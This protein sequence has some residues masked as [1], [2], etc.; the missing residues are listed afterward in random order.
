MR[1]Q[2]ISVFLCTIIMTMFLSA[3]GKKEETPSQPTVVEIPVEE[4]VTSQAVDKDVEEAVEDDVVATE[5]DKGNTTD[6]KQVVS[7]TP[8]KNSA[9]TTRSSEAVVHQ[10]QYGA[11]V[12]GHWFTCGC[13]A[14]KAAHESDTLGICSICGVDV[15]ELEAQRDALLAQSMSNNVTTRSASDDS[16]EDS[17]DDKSE[18][19]TTNTPTVTPNPEYPLTDADPLAK[20]IEVLN[21]ALWRER[22]NGNPMFSLPVKDFYFAS[23]DVTASQMKQEIDSLIGQVPCVK[24]ITYVTSQKDG[25]DLDSHATVYVEEDALFGSRQAFD[26]AYAKA[27]SEHVPIKVEVPEDDMEEGNTEGEKP[28][29]GL[30]EIDLLNMT[31]KVERAISSMSAEEY[32]RFRLSIYEFMLSYAL[33]CNAPQTQ[34]TVYTNRYG[35]PYVMDTCEVSFEDFIQ[36]FFEY[37]GLYYSLQQY[38]S[39]NTESDK[40]F[41]VKMVYPIID[42]HATE[43]CFWYEAI[44]Q[45]DYDT[46]RLKFTMFPVYETVENE[47]G[48]LVTD[49]SRYKSIATMA[50]EVNDKLNQVIEDVIEPDMSTF[51]KEYALFHYCDTYYQYDDAKGGMLG[52]CYAIYDN[53]YAIG[54][55][56][57]PDTGKKDEK[58]TET[59]T[60]GKRGIYTTAMT[61]WGICVGHADFFHALCTKVGIQCGFQSSDTHTW[62]TVTINGSSYIVDVGKR[63]PYPHFNISGSWKDTYTVIDPEIYDCVKNEEWYRNSVYSTSIYQAG[64]VASTTQ[65]DGEWVYYINFDDN[66]SLYKINV[67]GTGNTKVCDSGTTIEAGYAWLTQPPVETENEEVQ[68][69]QAPEVWKDQWETA[70][71][72]PQYSGEGYTQY[73]AFDYRWA[74]GHN[75][76]LLK[77]NGEIVYKVNNLSKTETIPMTPKKEDVIKLTLYNNDA[78]YNL[79]IISGYATVDTAKSPED[80]LD[81]ILAVVDGIEYPIE[82]LTE[83]ENGQRVDFSFRLPTDNGMNHHD[84]EIMVVTEKG[85][86]SRKSVATQTVHP[87]GI[88]ES[89]LWNDMYYTINGITA[90]E[91]RLFIFMERYTEDGQLDKATTL[92]INGYRG[93]DKMNTSFVTYEEMPG[94]FSVSTEGG[95]GF[96][97]QLVED[98]RLAIGLYDNDQVYIQSAEEFCYLAEAINK[99]KFQKATVEVCAELDFS[100]LPDGMDCPPIGLNKAFMGKWHGNNYKMSGWSGDKHVFGELRNATLQDVYISD[101]NVLGDS[102]AGIIGSVIS[103]DIHNLWVENSNIQGTHYVGVISSAVQSNVYDIFLDDVKISGDKYVGGLCGT[104]S[105]TKINRVQLRGT[106]DISGNQYVGGIVGYCDGLKSEIK[107]CLSEAHVLSEQGFVG[108]IVGYAMQI[109]EITHSMNFGDVEAKGS[110]VG[111]IVGCDSNLSKGIYHVE[112][113]GDVQGRQYVGGIAGAFQNCERLE[114]AVNNGTVTG[115]SHVGGISGFLNTGIEPMLGCCLNKGEVSAEGYIG[116]ICGQ[117]TGAKQI[118]HSLCTPSEKQLTG[119]NIS[120]LI[121]VCNSDTVIITDAD[122][123]PSDAGRQA[124]WK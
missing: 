97:I 12:D 67:D 60:Q 118:L 85:C 101:C 123:M 68:K 37:K 73:G 75:F 80:S 25:I 20:N 124:Y 65:Q 27:K 39:L 15:K 103:T 58:L 8:K 7:S 119:E 122:G 63:A 46:L 29:E 26:D 105:D 56:V 61:G 87:V 76:E 96:C 28:E 72:G 113:Y 84:L 74:I 120:V 41:F 43:I 34:D 45:M 108:G 22:L 83:S 5:E 51:A 89:Y 31:I 78:Y 95:T 57:N 117:Y 4:T 107:N 49:K 1:K 47:D 94:Y 38:Y 42:K 64:Y 93:S 23:K 19:S 48:S 86:I 54:V 32:N 59:S 110:Q 18:D 91:G 88:K 53:P 77:E 69:P 66:G 35:A 17:E 30:S 90:R 10:H 62:N 6:S 33:Q 44:S 36:Y 81:R 121:G 116:E 71:Y 16:K 106:Q 13:D 99:G 50:K 104:A 100:D 52:D 112:N 55:S 14:T 11:D 2:V 98:E 82:E 21:S 3:C 111:G 109:G 114:T 40:D 24:D 115:K 79:G 92:T 9:V 70:Q 102:Y